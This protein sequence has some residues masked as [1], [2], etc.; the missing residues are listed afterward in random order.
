MISRDDKLFCVLNSID[1][2]IKSNRLVCYLYIY[3]VSGLDI[4]FKYKTGMSTLKSDKFDVYLNYLVSEGCIKINRSIV[5]I[6]SYGEEVLGNF[7]FSVD[8]IEYLDTIKKKLNNLND[9]ELFFLVLLDIIIS[10]IKAQ[11]GV[12]GL[13]KQR[14]KIKTTLKQLTNIYSEEN[15]NGAISMLNNFK[16]GIK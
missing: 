12:Q 8:E 16:E 1:K 2:E 7:I 15:F 9:D 6:T 13:I 3:Q 14:D 5:S 10:E 4:N 11:A